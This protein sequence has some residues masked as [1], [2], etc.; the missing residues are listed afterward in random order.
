MQFLAVL[1]LAT[2]AAWA[3]PARLGGRSLRD[4]MRRGLGVGFLFTGVSHLA[5]P[6]SFLVY[7]TD[8]VPF[9]EGIV[10]AT[11]LAEVI[12]GLALFAR[13]FRRPVG[14]AMAAYLVLVFPANVYAAVAGVDET[15]PGLVDAAWYP[16]VRLPFQALFVWWALRSTASPVPSDR[17]SPVL[18]P[19]RATG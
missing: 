7:F 6:D 4:A 15:L 2:L 13:R 3:L 14:L 9:V 12:G 17:V 18:Q 16:W 19:G 1:V 10:S 5:M 8:W 11:G